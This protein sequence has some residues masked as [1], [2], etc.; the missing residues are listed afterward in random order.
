MLFNAIAILVIPLI[1]ERMKKCMPINGISPKVN[2]KARMG[3]KN[4]FN[5]FAVQ[6]LNHDPALT[7]ENFPRFYSL[8]H[9][10]FTFCLDF[11]YPKLV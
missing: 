7:P 3:F 11:L 10:V 2:V 4:A 9:L 8:Y 5:T 6:Y 1:V